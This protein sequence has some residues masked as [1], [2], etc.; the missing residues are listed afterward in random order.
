MSSVC[1]SCLVWVCVLKERSGR[2]NEEH[3]CSESEEQASDWWIRVHYNYA[4][5]FV[6]VRFIFVA[7][8]TVLSLA[9]GLLQR[10]LLIT[11]AV[12]INIG[13]PV[14]SLQGVAVPACRCFS[15][16]STLL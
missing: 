6:P 3:A 14:V 1:A 16:A 10:A 2:G 8:A 12:T 13:E 4:Q 15:G 11:I 9:V 7:I 5:A